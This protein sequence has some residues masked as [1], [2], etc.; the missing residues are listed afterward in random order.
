[1]NDRAEKALTYVEREMLTDWR[2]LVDARRRRDKNH[3][4]L[5]QALLWDHI[6]LRAILTGRT[7]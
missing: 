3:A 5:A 6:E 2:A 7:R 1:M 4:R